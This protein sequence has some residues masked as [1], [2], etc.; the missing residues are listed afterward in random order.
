MSEFTAHNIRFKDGSMSMPSHPTLLADEARCVATLRFLRAFYGDR[1]A[2]KR[3]VDLGCLEGGY[4]L[5]FARVGMDSLGVEV[6][7][8][9]FRNCQLVQEKSGFDN[10][11]FVQDDVWNTHRYGPFDIAYCC[12]LLYHLDRPY[13]FL[14]MLGSVVKECVIVNTHFA[15][16]E[17][18]SR[19]GL[20]PMTIHEGMPGRWVEEHGE[21]D[22][23]V[24]DALRW[25]SWDNQRSFWMTREAHVQAISDAGFKLV[26]EHWDAAALSPKLLAVTSGA[27]YRSFLRAVFIGIRA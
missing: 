21:E 13:E 7:S 10:L 3:I 18:E 16:L 25:A 17:D 26:L 15:P 12:G 8:S 24:L 5:E 11:R 22:L 27:D 20:G 19:F 9:N 2:T 23:A 4:A 1:L 14:S 6:R